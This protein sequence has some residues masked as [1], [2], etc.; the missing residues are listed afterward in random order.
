MAN[1]TDVLHRLL[2]GNTRFAR[3][4]S[5]R[6]RLADGNL[7]RLE[8]AQQA[9]AAVLC[10]SDARVPPED[11]FDAELGSLFEVRS[12]GNL[13]DDIALGSLEYACLHAGCSVVLVLGHDDCGA[14]K[15]AIQSQGSQEP[16]A[17]PSIAAVLA[18]LQPVIE[19][20]GPGS[21]APGGRTEAAKANVR[22]IGAD[23]LAR[24]AVLR[25]MAD[26]GRII[27][28][29]GLLRHGDGRVEMVD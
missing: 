17:S 6:H 10:C 1:P 24:S 9:R 7:E 4:E 3:G 27:L 23:I 21:Q 20:L 12:A 22:S 2:E 8:A 29:G 11:V 18:T 28:Q 14:I 16:P 5:L 15:A 19:S 26:E 25:S 13:L